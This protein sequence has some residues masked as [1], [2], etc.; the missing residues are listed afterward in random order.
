[1]EQPPRKRSEDVYLLVEDLVTE[2]GKVT[3][4]MISAGGEAMIIQRIQEH[5][6][7]MVEVPVIRATQNRIET[8]VDVLA[9]YVIGPKIPDPLN[10]G[11]WLINGRGEPLRKP[12]PRWP[13]WL[14]QAV[15]QTI[16]LATA[17]VI[18]INTTAA[19]P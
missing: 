16:T 14:I 6:Q 9:D 3:A 7:L 19:A 15:I 13:R 5:E 18:L 4:V 12:K 8:T 2:L 1:M 10:P 11:Q 17:L